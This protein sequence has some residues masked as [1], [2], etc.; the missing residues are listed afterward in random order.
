ME[1]DTA[2]AIEILPRLL[3]A[4]KVTLQATLGGTLVA[5]VLGLAIALGQQSRRRWLAATVRFMAE[6]IRRTPLL[7]QLFFLFYVLPE[8]GILLPRLVAG[9]LGLGLHSAAYMAEVYRAG[10]EAVPRGQWEA[11]RALN[12]RTRDSWRYVILPQAV[13]PTVPMLGNYVVLM[14]KE[15]ALLSVIAVPE[16][17]STA[18]ALGNETYRY[19]EPIVLIGGFYMIASLPV[20]FLLRR[21]EAR[22]P[23]RS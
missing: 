18:R 22:Y 16:L 6:F 2:Y 5:L 23:L 3:D 21:L 15:T 11:A 4:F 8:I 14:F 9:I 10:I 20:M 17:M 19:L 7:V 13:P 1:W 12:Y